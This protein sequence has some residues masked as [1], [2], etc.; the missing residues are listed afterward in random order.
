MIHMAIVSQNPTTG[1]IEK[2]FEELSQAQLEEKLQSASQMAKAWK[3]TFFQERSFLMQQTAKILRQQAGDLAA[4]MTLEMGKTTAAGLAEIEKCAATCEFYADQAAEFLSPIQI[5]TEAA[6]SFVRFDPFGVVLAVMPWNFPFWQVFRFAVPALMAGNVGI[7]KHASNVPQCALAIEKIFLESGFPV[8]AFQTLLVSAAGV[9]KLIADER[10]AA[11]TLTGSEMA[12]ALVASQAGKAIKKTVLELGGSDP[13]I[14]LEDADVALAAKI[15]AQARM[16]NN[17]G[18]SCIAAK[19]FI[20]QK[21]VS[22]EF[23][24]LLAQEFEKLK[25]GDPSKADT[26]V[27]PLA[28]EQILL[29]VAQQVETSIEKGAK[30]ICGGKRLGEVGFF[31][32]PTV[33]SEVVAGMPVY[34]E[35]VFGPVAPVIV[36]IDKAEAVA[37]A[38]NSQYG[39]GAT[40]FTKN[41]KVA[42]EMA[43]EIESGA[44]FINGMVRSDQRLPFGGVKKS[45]YGR[46]LGSFGIREFV[47]IKTV[48][49]AE[50][51]ASQSAA[52]LSE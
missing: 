12:G 21:E 30:L 19:R 50:E 31:F 44:V 46:E 6:E 25:I 18:Q 17:V 5:K 27:G 11:V 1:L 2:Q 16:Q 39:L 37:V 48:V 33:L 43:G 36:V 35:E 26:Q 29:T 23:T 20:V 41:I 14:V 49:V 24:K 51:T 47:N 45:G 40:I 52:N 10:V 34:D 32:Q 28:T 13:F 38:N 42:K 7:L 8:G 4:L 22:V 15:A 9:E 3:Q